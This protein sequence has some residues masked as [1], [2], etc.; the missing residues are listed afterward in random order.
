MTTPEQIMD[1]IFA[2]RKLGK[3][4]NECGRSEGVSLVASAV[5][6]AS[7]AE[8]NRGIEEAAKKCDLVEPEMGKEWTRKELVLA[9]WLGRRIRALRLPRGVREG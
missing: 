7:D 1:R 5:R 2:H 6:K 9:K 4:H 3:E 8:F